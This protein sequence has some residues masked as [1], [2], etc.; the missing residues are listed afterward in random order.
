MAVEKGTSCL[1]FGKGRLAVHAAD[2]LLGDGMKVLGVIPPSNEPSWTESLKQW[3]ERRGVAVFESCGSALASHPEVDVGVSIFHDRIFTPAQISRFQCLVNLHNGPLPRY[4]GVRPINW[5]LKNG[6][7]S[8]GVTL[9][10]IDPGI[11]SGDVIGQVLFGIDPVT[12][13]VED[14]YERCLV[15]GQLLLDVCLPVIDRL[16]RYPQN[17]SSAIFYSSDSNS[18]LGE[19]QDWRRR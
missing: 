18:Q 12:E 17:D 8:H 2:K 19:R 1:V 15:A 14:V 13:E 6:E 10:D 9:H 3:A 7:T 5:A 16:P 4:R 11:D